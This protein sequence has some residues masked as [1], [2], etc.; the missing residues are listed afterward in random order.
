MQK[1]ILFYM[2][3]R[4]IFLD[5]HTIRQD[6]STQYEIFFI[7][8]FLAACL[9]LGLAAYVSR[10]RTIQS[11]GVFTLLLV[12]IGI[13]TGSIGVGYIAKTESISFIWSTVRMSAV[14]A[15]PVLWLI[16][17]LQY[18]QYEAGKSRRFI[19]YLSIIPVISFIMMITNSFHMLFLKEIV[20][21]QHGEF[22]IDELWITG[23]WF[24]VHAFYSYTLILIADFLLV[25]EASIR[26][27]AYQQQAFFLVFGAIFPLFVNILFTFHLIPILKVNYDPFGFIITGIF[28]AFGVFQFKLFD[29]NPL[30]KNILMQ[31]IEDLILV[32]DE[33]NR[34]VEVNP[35]ASMK[36]KI[37]K[38]Q[39]I[40]ID[41]SSCLPDFHFPFGETSKHEYC[42]PVDLKTCYEAQVSPIFDRK[43]ILGHVIIMRDI[44]ERKILLDKLSQLAITDPLTNL[45]N[46]RHFLSLAEKEIERSQRYGHPFSVCFLDLDGFKKVN[47]QYGHEKGDLV[48]TEISKLIRYSFRATDLIARY[49]GDEFIVMMLETD[50]PE[51]EEIA[52]RIQQRFIPL[53]L[54][55][56]IELTPLTVSIGMMHFD[57]EINL[58]IKQLINRA[59]Q[60]MYQAKQMGENCL[61]VA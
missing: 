34:I 14:F 25:K 10:F 58:N 6:M 44:S 43:L 28:F 22:L 61:C 52:R 16:F 2:I 39:V 49:G 24:Y 21:V 11:V 4:V 45:Y 35:A 60:L 18:C 47:D 42:P 50:P 59:D 38:D 57:P 20:Y 29:I 41:F 15:V 51:A 46:R 56:G 55:L 12:S 48:L 7:I 17:T 5:F 36:L 1:L 13:W 37:E 3:F 8:S 31:N 30:A 40:G 53:S 33:K 23:P 32:V 19:L 26:A 27:R 54:E 9:M